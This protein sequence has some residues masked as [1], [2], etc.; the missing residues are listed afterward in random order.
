M[1]KADSPFQHWRRDG[2]WG[3][4]PGAADDKGGDAVI[5][6]ALRAMQQAGTL[7]NADITVFLTG[8][9][10]D[11]GNP[12]EVARRNLIAAGKA[13]DVA[14]DFEGLVRDQGKDM[15]S[16]ARRS[17][18]SWTVEVKATSAHS[19]GIFT[20]GSGYGAIYEAGSYPRQLS[21]GSAG[22]Q[23]DL[24]CRAH[25]RRDDGGSR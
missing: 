4:G 18:G 11:A 9:E 17:A 6:A 20:A 5:V 1:F 3:H 25:R 19:S 7:K 23:A 2:N 22:G 14:L 24:Q 13:A 21:E 12:I 16:T 10:E 8:D 15:G